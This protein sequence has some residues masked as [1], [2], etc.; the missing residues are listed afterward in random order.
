MVCQMKR[1]RLKTIK[2]DSETHQRLKLM[3]A[4][5]ERSIAGILREV[6]ARRFRKMD[7]IDPRE[8]KASRK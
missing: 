3:A 4:A 5:E 7:A 1:P 2:V 6:V 8:A